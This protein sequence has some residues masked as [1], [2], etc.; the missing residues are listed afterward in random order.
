MAAQDEFMMI[1]LHWRSQLGTNIACRYLGLFDKLIGEMQQKCPAMYTA[2]RNEA[3]T[4][5]M[6]MS[7][8]FREEL[9]RQ[10]ADIG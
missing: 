9:T 7:P 4:W 6:R 2:H 8:G 10:Y 3:L 5:W 1:F